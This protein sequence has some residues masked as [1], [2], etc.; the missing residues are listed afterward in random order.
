MSSNRKHSYTMKRKVL[1]S[2]LIA[3]ATCT[4]FGQAITKEQKAEVL[5]AVGEILAKRAF[6]AGTD[7]GKWPAFLEKKKEEIDKAVDEPSFVLAV[8]SAIREFGS[9]HI[10]LLSPAS[11]TQRETASVVGIGI[12]TRREEGG[13]RVMRVFEGGGAKTAGI[14]PGDLISLVDGKKFESTSQ[15]VGTEGTDVTVTVTRQDKSNKDFKITRKRYST[16]IPETIT[17]IDAD[18]AKVEIPSFEP[19]NYDLKNVDKIMDEAKKAKNLILD[20]RTNGGGLVFNMDHLMTHFLPA[21]TPYGTFIDRRVADRFATETKGD[22][23][24]VVAVAKWFNNPSRVRASDKTSYKG[25]VVVLVSGATGSAAEIVAAALKDNVDAI[26]IGTKSAGAVLASL[27]E[28]LPGEFRLQYPVREFV[29]SG[30]VRLEGTGVDAFMTSSLPEP[31]GADPAIEKAKAMFRL[32]AKLDEMAKKGGL[33]KSLVSAG[34]PDL[35]YAG[36]MLDAIQRI[37][38]AIFQAKTVIG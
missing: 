12:G 22:A 21:G 33:D 25:H 26:P 34:N 38:G 8:N 5:T 28:K 32:E 23:K 15:I 1:L 4:S 16:K 3:L 14:V 36:Q 7:F 9:S 11:A 31:T 20:L 29:T 17:W 27:F 30:M 13:L 37:F 6:V 35:P 2:L 24:D 10:A 18:T 19:A